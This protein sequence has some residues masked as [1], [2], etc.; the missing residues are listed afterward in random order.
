M[1]YK[2]RFK[3]RASL[4]GTRE[5]HLDLININLPVLLLDFLIGCLHRVHRGH[6]I[7]QV[8]RDKRSRLHIER[9]LLELSNLGLVHLLLLQRP[10]SP[11]FDR[12][13]H[14]RKQLSDGI[15]PG[16]VCIA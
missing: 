10:H 4:W 3:T 15:P 14:G 16:A 11:L 12:T 1:F 7:P 2:A 8:L 13:L 6:G 5:A 9:L